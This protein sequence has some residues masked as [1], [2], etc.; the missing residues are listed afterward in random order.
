MQILFAHGMNWND[1]QMVDGK[2]WHFACTIPNKS[3]PSLN[4]NYEATDKYGLLAM[5]NVIDQVVKDQGR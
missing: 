5:Q 1:L 4:R 2:Q 3:N